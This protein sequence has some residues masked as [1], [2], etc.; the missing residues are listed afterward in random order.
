[1]LCL[2]KLRCA[3]I[4]YI[5]SQQSRTLPDLNLLPCTSVSNMDKSFP[6]YGD[7]EIILSLGVSICYYT[8]SKETGNMFDITYNQEL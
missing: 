7:L 8:V 2:L 1:M 4:C 6:I 3:L 5:L